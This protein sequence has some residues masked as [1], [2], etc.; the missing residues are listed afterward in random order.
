[1]R[2]YWIFLLLFFSPLWASDDIRG[3]W[4]TVNEEGVVQTVVAIYEYD[5]LYYGRIIAIFNPDGSLK[6]SIYHPIERAPGMVGEPFYCGLDFILFLQQV[7]FKFKG[8]IL[9]PQKGDIYTSELWIDGQ[10]LIVRG[11]L[12]MFGKSFRWLALRPQDLPS[13]FKLPDLSTLK[14]NIHNTK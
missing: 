12:L 14:P 6:E 3:F 5:G 4:K 8:K 1:M 11:K 7:G 9:D 13:N 10:D 2:R